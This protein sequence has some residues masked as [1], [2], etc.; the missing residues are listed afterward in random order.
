MLDSDQ[1]YWAMRVAQELVSNEKY[2]VL[3]TRFRDM[4]RSIYADLAEQ[5]LLTDEKLSRRELESAMRLSDEVRSGAARKRKK[6][7]REE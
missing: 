7:A 2:S 6:K 4:T 3:F 5:A 1:E